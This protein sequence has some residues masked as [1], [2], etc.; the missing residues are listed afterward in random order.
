MR[1]VFNTAFWVAALLIVACDHKPQPPAAVEQPPKLVK[2]Y[3]QNHRGW[4]GDTIV[5]RLEVWEG[6]SLCFL[7]VDLPGDGGGAVTNLPVESCRSY[8][9]PE[10]K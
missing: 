10:V 1:K 5:Q 9:T 2:L 6:P 3:E 7:V 4:G 8:R